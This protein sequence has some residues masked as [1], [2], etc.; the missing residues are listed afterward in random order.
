MK[1]TVKELRDKGACK[2]Q[3]R[4]FKKEWPKGVEIT[5]EA[6]ER[7]VELELDLYWFADMFLPTPALADFD[8]A[9]ELARN[10][11]NKVTASAW[12]DF[13]KAIVPALYQFIT[14]YKL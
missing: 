6:L 14:D 5:L 1:V 13:N 4:V 7:A 9:M 8:K 3:V 12:N 11:L 10:E 2:R